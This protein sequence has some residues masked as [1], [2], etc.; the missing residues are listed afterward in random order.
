MTIRTVLLLT[1][2]L[3]ATASAQH[4]TPEE[5]SMI[6]AVAHCWDQVRNLTPE[7]IMTECRPTDRT[8]YWWTPETAPHYFLS[9]W[10]EGLWAAWN[11]TLIS[12]DLR[13]IR[14]Q[15]DGDF[16]FIFFHGIRVYRTAD[17]ARETESW[18]GY[19]VWK[20]TAGGWGF[21]GGMG[22]PDALNEVM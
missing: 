1:A 4:W 5:Q 21:H 12:Q 10:N 17:G 9:G 11:L 13:P 20:R 15:V 8:V 22:T 19:E 2:V 3:P 14:V 7:H 18:K 16:G 6:N